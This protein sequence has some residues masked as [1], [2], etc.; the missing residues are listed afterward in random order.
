MALDDWTLLTDGGAL[1]LGG[2]WHRVALAGNGEEV[3][4]WMPIDRA[5]G[6]EPS[7]RCDMTSTEAQALIRGKLHHLTIDGDVCAFLY[8]DV[9][10]GAASGCDAV[11]RELAHLAARG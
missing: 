9:L 1:Q 2:S 8:R 11:E 10:K 3:R 5:T 7:L 6:A 4:A